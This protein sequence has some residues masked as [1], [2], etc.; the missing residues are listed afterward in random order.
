LIQKS[1][2]KLQSRA[3]GMISRKNFNNMNR[4]QNGKPNSVFK[5]YNKEEKNG[6]SEQENDKLKSRN[7]LK[8]YK[9]SENTSINN[10]VSYPNK[11]NEKSLENTSQLNK[12]I[13]TNNI[14]NN[15]LN[16]E[17]DEFTEEINNSK[18]VRLIF[19]LIFIL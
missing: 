3:R 10:V 7:L 5:F 12:N 6:F 9:D 16:R 19:I 4:L 2:I 11:L 15:Y 17:E 14:T 18:I 8:E 13:T 1:L